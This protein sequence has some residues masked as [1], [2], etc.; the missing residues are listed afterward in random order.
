MATRMKSVTNEV[1]YQTPDMEQL[2]P[3][4]YPGVLKEWTYRD[5]EEYGTYVD[6][7]FEVGEHHVCAGA[8]VPESGEIGPRTKL[9]GILS[10]MAESDPLPE[11]LDPEDFLNESIGKPFSVH[12]E[13]VKKKGGKIVE[14]KA[15]G[16]PIVEVD[17]VFGPG[18]DPNVQVQAQSPKDYHTL[19]KEAGYDSVMDAVEGTIKA[20]G[21]DGV[22]GKELAAQGAKIG[23][24]TPDIENCI[25]SLI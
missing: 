14:S 12:V 7:T 19:L 11:D 1:K 23:I 6:L 9:Y 5:T 17:V 2:P 21:K 25:H 22:S 13:M 10:A 15:T 16:K 3:G 8:A 18:N 24:P 20:G 4:K